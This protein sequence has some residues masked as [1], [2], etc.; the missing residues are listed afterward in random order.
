MS[1]WVGQDKTLT[2]GKKVSASTLALAQ[3][4]CTWPW[5]RVCVHF[6]W[7]YVCVLVRACLHSVCRPSHPWQGF[8]PDPT[9][10]E[11]G[12]CEVS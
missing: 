12:L 2:L 9:G 7:V 11:S 1:S 10:V 6:V 5:V 8:S 3:P 4:L